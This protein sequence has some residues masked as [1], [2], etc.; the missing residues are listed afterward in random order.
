[1]RQPSLP[2]SQYL[3][4]CVLSLG[5]AVCLGACAEAI[6]DRTAWIQIGKT[7]KMEVIARYGE[8]DLVLVDQEGETAIYRPT[9]AQQL[10]PP[11]QVPMVQ[12]GPAGLSTTQLQTI[13]PGLRQRDTTYLRP[14]KEVRIRY[15]AQGIVQGIIQ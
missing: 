7:T 1:M 10:S 2:R 5:V 13:E 11:V 6:V 9:A 15:D 4:V 14:R 8:P 3:R 12:P